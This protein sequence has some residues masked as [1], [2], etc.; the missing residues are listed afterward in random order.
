VPI[1]GGAAISVPASVRRI[2]GVLR[3]HGGLFFA[4]ADI[5]P[6]SP[7]RVGDV[8]AYDMVRRSARLGR[9]GADNFWIISRTRAIYLPGCS[10]TI[11]KTSMVVM[12][13]TGS[14]PCVTT[15]R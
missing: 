2:G 13:P 15:N 1:R 6:R 9:T 3:L 8:G 7:R 5:I 12:M 11:F 14:L 10:A 4:L